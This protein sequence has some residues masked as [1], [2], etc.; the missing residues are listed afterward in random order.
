[1]MVVKLRLRLSRDL[2]ENG[3]RFLN[4]VVLMRGVRMNSVIVDVDVLGVLHDGNFHDFGFLRNPDGYRD[5]YYPGTFPEELRQKVQLQH[6]T[7]TR[8]VHC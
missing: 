8:Q 2:I 4:L 6:S 1:M 7:L 3:Q 5:W